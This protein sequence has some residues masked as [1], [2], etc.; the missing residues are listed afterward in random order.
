MEYILAKCF[1][2][3]FYYQMFFTFCQDGDIHVDIYKTSLAKYC[4]KL[5]T[6]LTS[7]L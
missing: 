2:V 4:K 7:V 5:V 1:V 3:V 6:D